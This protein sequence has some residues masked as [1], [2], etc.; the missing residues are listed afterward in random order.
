MGEGRDPE[1]GGT[2]LSPGTKAL[3]THSEDL[4]ALALQLCRWPLSIILG[5]AIRDED[6][7][8]RGQARAVRPSPG[9]TDPPR[10]LPAVPRA[11]A[12]QV[13]GGPLAGAAWGRRSCQ[14]RSGI[15]HRSV[16]CRPCSSAAGWPSGRLCHRCAG[17]RGT[18]PWGAQGTRHLP[19]LPP[20]CPA[21]PLPGA[22]RGS[23]LYCATAKRTA[24][25]PTTCTKGPTSSSM[26]VRMARKL[27]LPMLDEPSTRKTMSA[28]STSSHTAAGR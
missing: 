24:F 6:A 3:L 11:T 5:L 25:S 12:L 21:R 20:H 7:D 28:S 18:P 26:K 16:C 2:P 9:P 8:L 22:H 4:D 13:P 27:F 19:A 17:R 15:R 23:S 1:P 14:R 10:P